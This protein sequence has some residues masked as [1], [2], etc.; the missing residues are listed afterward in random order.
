MAFK[1]NIIITGGAGFIG[2]HVVRRFVDRYPQYRIVN[3]DKLTYAGNLANLRDIED[4][5]NYVFEKAD[6][7][8]FDAMLALIKK[9]SGVDKKGR[10]FPFISDQKYNDAIK[11]A[12][13]VAGIT[14]EV[15]VRNSVSGLEEIQPINKIA[16]S[17]LARRTFI[18]NLYHQVADPNI[19]G[20]MSGHVEGSKAFARYRD[21]DDE[22]LKDVIG[23]IG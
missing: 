2:C 5:D 19:I 12:F 1:R 22:M 3:V 17:H 4:R 14:R 18:G 8:D 13:T 7:C 10:L 16:S 15:V 20:K 9:Y 23:K 11:E 6:I 21:I